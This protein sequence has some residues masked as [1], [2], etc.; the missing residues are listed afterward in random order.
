MIVTTF[1]IFDS[2]LA[3][4]TRLILCLIVSLF[5]VEIAS[6]FGQ[7]PD[8]NDELLQLEYSALMFVE[9]EEYALKAI[10]TNI[11]AFDARNLSDI[12]ASSVMSLS[13]AKAPLDLILLDPP[14]GTSAG[15]VALDRML[16]LGWIAP[17]TWI[18][19]ATGA[20]EDVAVKGLTH[21]TERKV[22]KAKLHLLRMAAD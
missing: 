14:Y 20:K 11:A 9:Q 17:A 12:R 2:V 22:G 7:L 19:L 10:R 13:A 21:D 15:E 6:V 18:A 4:Q 8:Q 16:R 5:L 3:H 1:T